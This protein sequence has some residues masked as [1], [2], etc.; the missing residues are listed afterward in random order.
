[1]FVLLWLPT[2]SAD[3]AGPEVQVRVCSLLQMC[4]ILLVLIEEVQRC[5]YVH[6]SIV[7]G[8]V[9]QLSRKRCKCVRI[10]RV[11]SSVPIE[12]V[13]TRIYFYSYY[14]I[15]YYRQVCLCYVW[16][17]LKNVL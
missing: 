5:K 1:M 15:Y 10:S 4:Q 6:T 16:S 12:K 3:Q 7:T 14:L 2:V 13:Q 17:N 11:I 9:P 8:S